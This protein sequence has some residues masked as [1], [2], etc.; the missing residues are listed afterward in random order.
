MTFSTPVFDQKNQKSTFNA[1]ADA[2]ETG[3]QKTKIVFP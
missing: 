1:S 3:G 2:T